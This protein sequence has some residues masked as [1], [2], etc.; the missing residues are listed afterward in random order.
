MEAGKH[1]MGNLALPTSSPC[2]QPKQAQWDLCYTPCV[3][4]S[5]HCLPARPESTLS[6]LR[7]GHLRP[8]ASAT[9]RSVCQRLAHVPLWTTE[10]KEGYLFTRQRAAWQQAWAPTAEMDHLQP[11]KWCLEILSEQHKVK[12]S[13]QYAGR[14]SGC[15]F[16]LCA[17]GI[18][19]VLGCH[20]VPC[21]RRSWGRRTA[22]THQFEVSMIFKTELAVLLSGSICLTG[23]SPWVLISALMGQGQKTEWMDER[24]IIIKWNNSDCVLWVTGNS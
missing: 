2:C 7:G 18:T 20:G 9:L 3:G 6:P 14:S 13:G 11:E 15:Q 12:A 24:Q 22:Q 19:V 1:R 16:P 8:G 5:S 10:R 17:S 21:G 4:F 23:T